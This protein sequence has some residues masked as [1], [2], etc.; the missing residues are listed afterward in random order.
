L[1]ANIS[2][3][4]KERGIPPHEFPL[5]FD[6]SRPVLRFAEMARSMG[7]GAAR[8]EKAW[9]IA[10]AINEALTHQGPFLI[11]LVLEGQTRPELVGV[12]CGQ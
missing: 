3:Y 4:W 11:D 2:A 1:Q 10:P 9:E 5:S 6:L 7:V 12:K 8:I